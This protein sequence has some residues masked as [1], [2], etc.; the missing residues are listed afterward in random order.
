MN[1]I[2]CN[3]DQNV[4]TNMSITLEDGSKVVVHICDTHADDAT[5]KSCREVYVEKQSKINDLIAQ[6]RALGLEIG[7]ARP[8]GL[9]AVTINDQPKRQPVVNQASQPKHVEIDDQNRFEVDAEIVDSKQINNSVGGNVQG[10]A[11]ESFGA[12]NIS[13]VRK[14]LPAEALAGKVTIE[15]ME[16]RGK[17][18]IALPAKRVDGTGTTIIKMV[19]STDTDLQ[20]RFKNMADRSK[21]DQGWNKL[22]HFGKDG[23]DFIPCPLC[24]GEC[25]VKHKSDVIACPKCNGNGL[26]S[27]QLS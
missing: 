10:A 1:C 26:I 13:N 14:L 4:N 21:S 12:H 19:Q 9:V 8:S 15:I 16:G 5:V 17:Q 20:T 7:P 2:F 27:Q 18:P 6:A 24:H 25:T 23:Y 3:T 22:N 11:V